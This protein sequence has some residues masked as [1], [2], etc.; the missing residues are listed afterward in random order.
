MKS[1][2]PLFS[3]FYVDTVDSLKIFNQFKYLQEYM[4][5]QSFTSR[6]LYISAIFFNG[7]G[8]KAKTSHSM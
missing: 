2:R 3:S 1:P 5:F 4:T 6:A 8:T 7:E